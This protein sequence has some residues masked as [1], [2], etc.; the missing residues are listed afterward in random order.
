MDD[1][2]NR[3]LSW[4]EV[5]AAALEHNLGAFRAR[6]EAG[7]KLL[8]VVKAN[9]YGH[10]LTEVAGLA[11]SL[12]VDA[13]GVHQ[14]DEAAQA[15]AAGWTGPVWVL[16]YTPQARLADG[17]GLGVEFTVYDAATLTELN[18]LGQAR[19][20]PA[21]CHLKLETGTHRQGIL[22]EDL[23]RF[24][25]IFAS[26]PGVRLAGVSTH[27]ANIE[28]TTDHAFARGQLDRFRALWL[29]VRAAGFTEAVPHAA[30]TAA[31]LVMPETCF[32][33]ARVGIGAYGIWPSRETLATLANRGE[34]LLQLRPVLAWKARVAQVKPVPA[35]AFVGYGCTRRTSRA[36]RIAVLPVGYYEGYDR[37]FSNL[38]HILVRGSRAP[39][40]GRVCMDMFMADVTD[41]PGVEPE[42]E[43]V[44]IGRQG[45]EEIRAADLAAIAQTIPYE[46]VSRLS[47]HLP[48]IVVNAKGAGQSAATHSG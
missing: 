31:V 4:C 8:L 25:G 32:G 40:L 24:L 13:L 33:C 36:S 21:P 11:P 45:D 10:G 29:R 43:A 42:D 22:A 14:L 18:R 34:E 12:G 26:S 39:V 19:R 41:I 17:L 46:I 48:R 44:L 27:F 35:G 5:D 23:D 3:L 9:A 2:R 37:R 47:P 7:T 30:C 16:G 15:R 38:A 28:D 1:P 20:L 6:L